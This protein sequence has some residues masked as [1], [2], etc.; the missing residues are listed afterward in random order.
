MCSLIESALLQA[1]LRVGRYASP[2]VEHITERISTFGRPVEEHKLALMM[3]RA[4]DACEGARRAGTPGA[5][6]TWFDVMTAAA[7]LLFKEAALDWIALEVGLGGKSD[8]TN[9]VN[10]EV[11]VV[12]N[13]ELEHTEV[14]GAS[15]DLIAREK[16]GIL[17]PGGV[18]VTTLAEDDLA[19]RMLQDR[20][21]ELRCPVVRTCPRPD[22]TIEDINLGLVEAV[23]DQLG[24]RGL[25]TRRENGAGDPVGGWLLDHGTLARARLPGRMERFDVAWRDVGRDVVRT[26]PAILDGAHV[27]F[28]LQGVLR[29]LNRRPDLPPACIAIVALA[30]DKD[31]AGFLAALSRHAAT[32]LWTVAP[33]QNRSHAPEEL[34]ALARSLGLKSE[35]EPEAIK[36]YRRGLELASETGAWVLITGSLYL[37]GALRRTVVGASLPKAPDG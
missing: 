21:D 3:L 33:G 23:L 29:D 28:N 7:F 5:D 15:R 6:A 13:V 19:G 36:A 11:A 18:L 37:V 30:A 2:H 1:G 14:L 32:V 26:I 16:V 25:R 4:L 27:P 10:A 31:A 20:A 35:V 8:S 34:D 12:T 9:V 22:A 17:K 24:R